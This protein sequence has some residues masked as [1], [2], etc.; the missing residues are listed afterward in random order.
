MTGPRTW[1]RSHAPRRLIA[2][3]LVGAG[4]ALATAPPARA[5][6]GQYLFRSGASR[7]ALRPGSIRRACCPA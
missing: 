1:L 6:G 7:T 4:A 2:V 5:A 3:A